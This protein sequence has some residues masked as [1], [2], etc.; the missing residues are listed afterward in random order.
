MSEGLLLPPVIQ[1]VSG[2]I[3]HP[4]ALADPEI[5]AVV[6]ST[7]SNAN[8]ITYFNADPLPYE[9]PRYRN[10]RIPFKCPCCDGHGK[11]A[12]V[13]G[14]YSGTAAEYSECVSCGG[15]GVVWGEA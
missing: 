3:E 4:V 2:W 12:T 5:S 9:A 15:T 6:T 1:R 13:V 7:G 10:Q 14:M 8:D 11:R